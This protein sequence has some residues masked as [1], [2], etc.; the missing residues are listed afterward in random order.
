MPNYNSYLPNI[1]RFICSVTFRNNHTTQ[2]K[3]KLFLNVLFSTDKIVTENIW[4]QKWRVFCF[5][6]QFFQWFLGQFFKC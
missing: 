5:H 3:V 1:N 4:K 2:E 6:Q